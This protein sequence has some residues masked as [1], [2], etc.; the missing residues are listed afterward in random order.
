[1]KRTGTDRDSVKSSLW[2]AWEVDCPKWAAMFRSWP[3][4]CIGREARLQAPRCVFHIVWPGAQWFR[5]GTG[6]SHGADGNEVQQDQRQRVWGIDRRSWSEYD[7]TEDVADDSAEIGVAA[8]LMHQASDSIDAQKTREDVIC[9][10]LIR[11]A[12]A[13]QTSDLVAMSCFV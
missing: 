12:L 1:M 5:G 3:L 10:Q 2:K 4:V 11:K 8:A 6:L 7:S 9:I 13:A